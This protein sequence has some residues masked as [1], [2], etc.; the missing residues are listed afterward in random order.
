MIKIGIVEDG[1]Y[2]GAKVYKVD[3]TNKE[4][5]SYLLKVSYDNLDKASNQ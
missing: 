4:R 2:S 3:D 5:N 1:N